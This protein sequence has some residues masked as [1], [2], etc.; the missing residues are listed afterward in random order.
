[1]KIV[2]RVFDNPFS[3]SFEVILRHIMCIFMAIEAMIVCGS[4]I[5]EFIVFNDEIEIF[6]KY[7][8]ESLSVIALPL[9]VCCF[10]IGMTFL[11][12]FYKTAYLIYEGL[13]VFAGLLFIEYMLDAVFFVFILIILSIRLAVYLIIMEIRNAK[14]KKSRRQNNDDDK[15]IL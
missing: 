4:I 1:M 3:E 15:Q 11:S 14:I 6:L 13:H 2:K 7:H 5:M 9:L 8:E 12:F 10:V